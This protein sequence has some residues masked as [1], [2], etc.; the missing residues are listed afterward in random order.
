MKLINLNLQGGVVYGPLIEFVKKYSPDIDI[1]CFQEVFHNALITRPL[2]GNVRPNL[3]SELKDILPNFNGYYAV[4]IENDVGGLAIFIKKSFIVNKVDN[5][6]IFPELNTTEDEN[7]D[8]YFSMGRNLQYVEFSYLE[9]TYIVFNFHGMWIAKGKAD[10]EKR[11]L[12]SEKIREIFDKLKGARILC[13]DLN[14]TPDTESIAILRKGNKDLVQEYGITST[15]SLS[16]G[17]SEVVDYVIVS[18]E[19]EVKNFETLKEEVSDHLPLFLD[20]K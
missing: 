19:V 10:T 1:F 13:T 17:R 4:P 8:S 11:I 3:F 18:L 2:L 20:F 15:R 7:D 14:V 9:K 16:K 12:Q 6:V 5:I